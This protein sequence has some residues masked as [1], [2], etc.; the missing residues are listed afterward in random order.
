MSCRTCWDPTFII[1]QFEVEEFAPIF[2]LKEC[3]FHSVNHFHF[4]I[5]LTL[6]SSTDF[7]QEL[8]LSIDCTGWHRKVHVSYAGADQIFGRNYSQ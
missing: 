3:T 1:Y 5:P 6:D 4:V 2:K 7:V 8:S